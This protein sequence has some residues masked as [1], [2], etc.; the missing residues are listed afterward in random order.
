MLVD[1][2]RCRGGHICGH[3]APPPAPHLFFAAERTRDGREQMTDP[4][5]DRGVPSSQLFPA[6]SFLLYGSEVLPHLP[7]L[8]DHPFPP[9]YV[10]KRLGTLGTSKAFCGFSCSRSTHQTGN[11]GNRL[12]LIDP[13]EIVLDANS[14][15]SSAQHPQARRNAVCVS[16]I[17]LLVGNAEM[18]KDFRHRD[19]R[20]EFR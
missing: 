9:V 13:F 6:V 3:P 8:A 7:S 20:R 16:L 17:A 19:G 15:S 4:R 18:A 10:S 14:L 5:P 2:P 1:A 12:G 11:T